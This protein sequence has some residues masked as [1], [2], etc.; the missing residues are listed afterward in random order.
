MFTEQ[1]KF[2]RRSLMELVDMFETFTRMEREQA[3]L[4]YDIAILGLQTARVRGLL[5]DGVRM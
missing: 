4:K 2:G 5:V 1:Y 3:S